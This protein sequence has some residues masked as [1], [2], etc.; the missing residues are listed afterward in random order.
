MIF[1]MSF[2]YKHNICVLYNYFI[3]IN[4]KNNMFV[5]IVLFFV[6]FIFFYIFF[7]DISF[8]WKLK[9][10]KWKSEIPYL[11]NLKIIKK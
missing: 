6:F 7:N 10:I 1:A 8:I 3:L 5:T 11:I 4:A 2:F 9:N